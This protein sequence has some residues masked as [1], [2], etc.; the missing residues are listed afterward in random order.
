[1]GAL[2]SPPD[3]LSMILVAAP[4]LLLFEVALVIDKLFS[5]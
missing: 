1:M 5:D 4:M 3:P 2:L